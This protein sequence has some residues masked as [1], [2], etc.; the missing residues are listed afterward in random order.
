MIC[1]V[2]TLDTGLTVP[3]F[4]IVKN[5]SSVDARVLVVMKEEIGFFISNHHYVTIQHSG[6]LA[7]AAQGY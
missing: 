1:R 3:I 2:L 5:W 6:A 7:E 4:L